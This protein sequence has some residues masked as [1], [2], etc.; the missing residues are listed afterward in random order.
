MNQAKSLTISDL[1]IARWFNTDQTFSIPA[2]KITAV[3][4]FQMLCPGCVLHGVPQ[5]NKIYQMFNHENLNVIGLHTVFE[6]HEAMTEVSLKAFLHEFR[7]PFPVGVDL[8]QEGD[9][10]PVTMKKFALKGTPSWLLFNRKGELSISL[11]GHIEDLMISALITQLIQA[12]EINANTIKII[13][14]TP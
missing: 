6:H 14:N 3:H 9:R 13:S 7:V 10:I 5:A 1:E 8:S 4:A 2:N 11:F 12:D